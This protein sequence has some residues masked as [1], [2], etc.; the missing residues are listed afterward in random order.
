M[1]IPWLYHILQKIWCVKI[2]KTTPFANK[3]RLISLNEIQLKF[4]KFFGKLDNSAFS[5]CAV[6]LMFPLQINGE[7]T[8][9]K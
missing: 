6:L 9:I 8:S 4:M 7:E 2:L 1:Q 3:A 5:S